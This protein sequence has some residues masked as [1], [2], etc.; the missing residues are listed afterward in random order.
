MYMYNQ[1]CL[2]GFVR[3]VFKIQ[4]ASIFSVSKNKQSCKMKT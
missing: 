2:H 4:A 3:D 1:V